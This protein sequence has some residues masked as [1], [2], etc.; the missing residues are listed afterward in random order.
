[1]SMNKKLLSGLPMDEESLAVDVIAEVGPRGQFLSHAHTRRQL[2]S[3]SGQW[4]PTLLN[5]DNRDRWLERG[6]SDL[7]ERARQKALELI[8]LSSPPP[9]EDALRREMAARLAK[10][11]SATRPDGR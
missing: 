9:L 7:R 11:E 1:V 6:G 8:A 3:G 4:R 10:L 5:R 2:R